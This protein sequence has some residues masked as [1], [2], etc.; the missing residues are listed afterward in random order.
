MLK[1]PVM[2]KLLVVIPSQ[3]YK[4]LSLCVIPEN[5]SNTYHHPL[6]MTADPDLGFV[7][8]GTLI[9][10]LTHP[11]D[12]KI[13]LTFFGYYQQHTLLLLLL[14]PT[15]LLSFR[16]C[17]FNFANLIIHSSSTPSVYYLLSSM[18][19]VLWPLKLL[20]KLDTITSSSFP[21]RLIQSDS[22]PPTSYINDLQEQENGPQGSSSCT[23][24]IW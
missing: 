12:N 5:V 10:L 9:P 8:H 1:T 22:V 14:P 3:V 17:Q 4:A 20:P 19:C 24:R 18:S 6:M 15:T 16:S 23:K 2:I 13:N 21:C 11:T 7:V